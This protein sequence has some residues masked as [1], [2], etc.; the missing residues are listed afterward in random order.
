MQF[1]GVKLSYY[2]RTKIAWFFLAPEDRQYL[3]SGI[4]LKFLTNVVKDISKD[5][6]LDDC[7]KG[8]KEVIEECLDELRND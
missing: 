4:A 2:I 7:C 3:L 1:R 8:N 5:M 6:N